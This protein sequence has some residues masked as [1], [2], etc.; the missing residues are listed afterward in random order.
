MWH[1]PNGEVVRVG[2]RSQLW[3]VAVVDVNVAY[4]SDLVEAQTVILQTADD[5]CESAAWKDQVLEAP[6]LLGVE[7]F[8]TLGITVRIVVKTPPERSGR[9]SGRCARRSRPRS[10]EPASKSP[11]ND[12]SSLRP[13]RVSE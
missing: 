8:A 2:N 4:S 12:S 5:V 13:A 3:S 6:D 1:V 7:A 11:F 10:T 9:C